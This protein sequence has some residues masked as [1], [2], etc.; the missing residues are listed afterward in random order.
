MAFIV[1]SLLTRDQDFQQ[2][3]AQD[4]EEA[5]ARNGLRVEVIFADNNAIEQIQQLF[6]YIYRPEAERPDAIVVQTVTGEGLE[7]VARNAAQAGIGWVL[8]NRK[9]AYLD[10]LRRKYPRLPIASVGTDP[11]EVGR[12]QGRQFRA[13]LPSGGAVLYIHGPIDTSAA[14]GRLAGMEEIVAGASIVIRKLAAQWT[15]ASAHKAVLS[16]MRLKTSE[17]FLPQVVGCQ[18]DSMAV[19]ARRAVESLSEEDRKGDWSSVIYTGCDGLPA[20]GQQL[21]RDGVLAATV[22]T[23]SN[24]GPAVDLVAAA[25][26]TRQ[27]PREVTLLPVSF[28][29]VSRIKP[30]AAAR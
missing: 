4:A 16:L 11:V 1:V 20:G 28:P 8:L 17:A 22:I 18:N 15:E 7:R 3:Q 10:D 27:C 25:L 19:G 26:R 6:K 29:E 23:A 24:S 14:A 5:A 2:L 30:G 13:L 9:V 12:I 21:V